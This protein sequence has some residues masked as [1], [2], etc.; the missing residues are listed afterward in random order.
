MRFSEAERE[1]L[2]RNCLDSMRHALDHFF[3][4]ARVGG[5]VDADPVAR[6]HHHK[7][8]ILSVDHVADCLLQ[9][10]L[11]DLDPENEC[12]RELGEPKY[13]A[14][15]LTACLKELAK[16]PAAEQLK[17]SERGLLDLL[18]DVH[19]ERCRLVHRTLPERLDPSLAAFA[20]LALR[21]CLR[22]RYGVSEEEFGWD[23]PEL[24]QDTFLAM[25]TRHY[26]H[27]FIYAELA[28]AEEHRGAP[29]ES[30]PY[31][32][33]LAVVPGHSHCEACFLAIDWVECLECG[34]EF[35]AVAGPPDAD[36]T[37]CPSCGSSAR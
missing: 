22:R 20:L 37:V 25:R 12:F 36:G 2:R 9:W 27:Y 11:N 24:L 8:A 34:A 26:D 15:S 18:E 23:E 6:R 29:V 31:C 7:W 1:G 28:V 17:G 32:A 14:P 21:R 3:E 30:C 35:A 33:T 4:L 10:M 16:G 13:R 5:G 19:R